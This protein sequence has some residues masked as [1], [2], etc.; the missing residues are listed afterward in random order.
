M[1]LRSLTILLFLI[2][3]CQKNSQIVNYPSTKK[4]ATVD[5]YFN[6]QVIDNYRWLEDDNAEGTKN[7][8]DK[9]NETTFSYLKNIPFRGQ[10]KN[11]LEELWDYERVT[12]PL[13][14]GDYTY[15]YKNTGLQNQY[16]IYREKEGLEAEIF[17]DPNT[18][19][20][21][22]TTS[23]SGLNFS[24]NGQIAAYSISE[25]GSD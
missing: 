20:E 10:I 6:S 12:A 19:S 13:K 15:Y 8:V 9:Q 11:R 24:K 16:V 25:G 4:I 17:L 3:S 7:W 14:E 22:G 2:I 23:L 1:Y 21:D 18:F 5:T